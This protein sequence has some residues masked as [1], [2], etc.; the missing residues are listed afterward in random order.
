MI[1]NWEPRRATST[2]T[3]GM[4]LGGYIKPGPQAVTSVHVVILHESDFFPSLCLRGKYIV[5]NMTWGGGGGGGGPVE[6]AAKSKD[7]REATR[8]Y[9]ETKR[10]K[11][12]RR[13]KAQKNHR[14]LTLNWFIHVP[15]PKSWWMRSP[16]EEAVIPWSLTIQT[17]MFWAATTP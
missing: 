9:W 3:D 15:G 12:P 17:C 7:L 10:T 11:C 1:R 5:W 16:R 13:K 2:F 8:R 14:C 4:P 6:E